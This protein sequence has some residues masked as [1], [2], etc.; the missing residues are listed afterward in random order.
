MARGQKIMRDVVEIPRR[1]RR[2]VVAAIR[3][4]RYSVAVAMVRAWAQTDGRTAR[5][6]VGAIARDAFP[7]RIT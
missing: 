2:G 4:G 7:G 5:R 1:I 3:V 6:I